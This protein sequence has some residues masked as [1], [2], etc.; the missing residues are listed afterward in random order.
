MTR[1][2][3]KIVASLIIL[4]VL[5]LG[6]VLHKDLDERNVIEYHHLVEMYIDD[7]TYYYIIDELGQDCTSRDMWEYY[8][9]HYHVRY[10]AIEVYE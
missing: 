2:E 8:T 10:K 7:N 5:W 9:K 4:V 6:A 3:C 1:I